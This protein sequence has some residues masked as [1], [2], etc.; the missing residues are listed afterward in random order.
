MLIGLSTREREKK[1]QAKANTA[2]K[3]NPPID[4]IERESS[5]KSADASTGRGE[6]R[7]NGPIRGDTPAGNIMPLQT[8]LWPRKVPRNLSP[9]GALRPAEHPSSSHS[10]GAVQLATT[11][12]TIPETQPSCT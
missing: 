2:K 11:L 8:L 7:P 5:A 12:S 3:E 10:I 9:Q 1:A 6:R 4:I